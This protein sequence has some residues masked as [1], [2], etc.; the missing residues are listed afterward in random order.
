MKPDGGSSKN[1]PC[2]RSEEMVVFHM[3]RLSLLCE[4]SDKT[5]K[6]SVILA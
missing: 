2:R 1:W 6:K 4:H 5:L 3:D